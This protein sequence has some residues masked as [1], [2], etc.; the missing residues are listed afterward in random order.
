LW[1]ELTYAHVTRNLSV[2][3]QCLRASHSRQEEAAMPPAPAAL[4]GIN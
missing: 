1:Q 4:E 2:F 3:T